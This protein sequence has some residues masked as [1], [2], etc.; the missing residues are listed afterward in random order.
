MTVI[1]G[2]LPSTW[3]VSVPGVS[4]FPAR[5]VE[6]KSSVCEPSPVTW[7]GAVYVRHEPP[8]SR[9]CVL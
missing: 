7:N 3:N 5:S 1:A 9:Y 8:S 4:T 6:R 2:G